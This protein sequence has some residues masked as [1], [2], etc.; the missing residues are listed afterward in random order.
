M[1][2]MLRTIILLVVLSITFSNSGFAQK[3]GKPFK[4]IITYSM[5]YSGDAVEP[6]QLAQ[7][8]KESILKV[9]ENKTLTEQGPASVIT[10]GDSK[11]VYTVV[12]LTSYGMKKYLI[13]QK[14]EEIEKDNKGTKYNYSEE[15]KEIL[16]YKT[17]KVEIIAPPKEDEED[18]EA[19]SAKITAYY[20]EEMGGE[21]VNFGNQMFHGVKG[22]VLEYEIVTPKMNVKGVAKIIEKG[23][24]KETDFLVPSD[25]TEITMEAFQEE[26]KALRGEE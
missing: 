25:G 17:K 22:M 10:N 20:T 8:P 13:T 3:K 11:V 4:G 21:E 15:G 7:L 5:T 23:K 2:N 18:A 16:G 26:M 12:D 19:G 9:Y 14:Q 24:V 1:K 6:A